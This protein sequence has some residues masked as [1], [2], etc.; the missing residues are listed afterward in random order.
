MRIVCLADTHGL[1]RQVAVP[2]GDVLVHAGDLTR[3]GNLDELR[4]LNT[5]LGE[6]PHPH[7]LVIAG[8]HDWDIQWEPDE[9]RRLLANTTYLCDEAVTIDGLIFYGSPWTPGPGWAF[10]R[11]LMALAYHW[12]ELPDGIDVLITHGPPLG[13]LDQ[14]HKG[15]RLGDE[16]LAEAVVRARPRLHIFGH[17]HEAYGQIAHRGTTFVNASA[18][19]LR[20]EPANAPIVIDLL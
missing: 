10:G 6:L 5:W 13:A 17:I 12:A 8:N 9:A 20:Y 19:T 14:N 2:P 3:Q 15:E 16:A 18:C 11:S 7:K 1:H 4:D